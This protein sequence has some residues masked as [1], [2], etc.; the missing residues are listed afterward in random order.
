MTSYIVEIASWFID[1]PQSKVLSYP[2]DCM[3][4]AEE[5]YKITGELK[6]KMLYEKAKKDNDI[7]AKK[8]HDI[9][10]GDKNE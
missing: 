1:D 7:L 9:L 3:L 8:D 4:A 6:F 10:M 2:Y 5:A